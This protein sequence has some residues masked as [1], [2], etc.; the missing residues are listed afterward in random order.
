MDDLAR[1]ATLAPDLAV[2]TIRHDNGQFN[3]VLI[4]ND[5]WVFRF[6]KSEAVI[7][8]LPGEVAFLRTIAGR[9]PLA[10]P[11]VAYVNLAP[12]HVGMGYPIL[13]GVALSREW[14]AGAPLATLERIGAQLGA[15]LRALHALPLDLFAGIA[16][17]D[18][19][20]EWADLYANIRAYLFPHM[21]ADARADVGARFEAFLA[22]GGAD[23]TPVPR[24]GDFGSGN[25]LYDSGIDSVTA[26]ID[27]GSAALGDPAVD[28]AAL[29]TMGES[30]FQSALVA[31]PEAVAYQ[32]R[33]AF[34]RSTFALQQAWYGLRDGS[35]EDFE[36]GIARYR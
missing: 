28:I 29:S 4:V 9:L 21:R 8:A 34:Y 36:Y 7:A 16:I 31:Y 24:H 25:A 22:T 32:E 3:D 20:D 13:P 18:R 11:N 30:V 14:L 5:A 19:V 10:T 23:W 27:F 33:A 2:E 35:Q 1:I 12:P 6:A 26:I 17:Q 15:F